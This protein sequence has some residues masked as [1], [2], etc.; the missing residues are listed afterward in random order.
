MLH[1]C[2]AGA[3]TV[4]NLQ[5]VYRVWQFVGLEHPLAQ[6]GCHCYWQLQW[7]AA[8]RFQFFQFGTADRLQCNFVWR[9]WDLSIG[10]VLLYGISD[11]EDIV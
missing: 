2:T 6:L 3:R 1:V 7:T 4:F 5:Y 9:A 11:D 10:G 8:P